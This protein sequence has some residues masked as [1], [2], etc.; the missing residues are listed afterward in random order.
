MQGFIIA[1]L[2]LSLG[3]AELAPPRVTPSKDCQVASKAARFSPH[4]NK[5]ALEEMVQVISDLTCRTFILPETVKGRISVVGP[6]KNGGLDLSAEQVYELFL[7]ALDANGLAL[8]GTG[9]ILR[10]VDKQR[11]KQG[12]IPTAF[13]PED[14]YTLSEQMV[15]RVLRVKHLEL[16][17]ARALLAGLT[18][19]AD[20]TAVQPDLLVVNEL[21]A[22]LH[23]LE[24]LLAAVDVE[25]APTDVMEVL[26]LRFAGAPDVAEKL[27]R[28]L[29]PKAGG[30]GGD[31]F[32]AVPD[33]RT[34]TLI[35]LGSSSQ[36]ARARGLLET[37]DQ[38]LPGDGQ[39]R[40]YRLQNA[41]AKE[42]AGNLEALVQGGKAK[43]APGA[44]GVFNGE[45][46]VTANESEN[47]L[48][49]V[50]GPADYRSLAQVIEALD[51]PKRQVFVEVVIME[52]SN[53]HERNVGVSMHA[54]PTVGGVP[55]VL[56]SQPTG[57]GSSA[58]YESLVG[59]S[60]LLLGVQGPVMTALSELVGFNLPQFGVLLQALQTS[61]EANV[62]STPY[63]LV[64]DNKEAE[65]NV[66]EKVPFN[67]GPSSDVLAK[68]ATTGNSTALNA[69]SLTQNIQREPVEL[70][71]TVKPHISAGD[72]IRLE[73]NQ[74]AEEISGKNSAGPIT[75]TRGQKTTIVAKDGEAV[76]LG[77][78][79]Q[80]RTLDGASKTPVLG[81]IPLLGHLFRQSSQTRTKMN[82][83]VFLTPHI[84]RG[85]EDYRAILRRKLEDRREFSERFYGEVPGVPP[86]LDFDRKPGPLAAF[87]QAVRREELRPENGGTG[88]PGERVISPDR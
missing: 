21:G 12:N 75:S 81:D 4:F 61:S 66:G 63:I 39:L 47:A 60:G 72:S 7:S 17:P 87:A 30:K 18:S 64:A 26:T 68:L 67:L 44:P 19:N 42:L 22:N 50:A 35:V 85:P 43:A 32:T 57:V 70:K 37:L 55:V 40:V 28:V 2:G 56:G 16:E 65:I 49:I 1:W 77:G 27:S 33:E 59:A 62:L 8:Y 83:L 15:T 78:I 52:V 86:L 73:L 25:K 6:E 29:A 74:Q 71:L 84:I 38:P 45:V 10:I 79:L 34:N 3:V 11:A 14:R 82:L 36:L 58:S 46:K 53:Q 54:V 41:D 20:V 76:V 80:E 48:L 13:D 31:A 51:Q 9:R 24:S 69:L 5:V 23:R 88:N